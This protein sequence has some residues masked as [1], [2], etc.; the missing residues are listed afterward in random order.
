MSAS[1]NFSAADIM[2]ANIKGIQRGLNVAMT[3]LQREIRLTLNKKGT[4]VGYIGGK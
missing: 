3:K 4:G 2:A 1:H